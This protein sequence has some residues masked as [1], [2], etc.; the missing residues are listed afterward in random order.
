MKSRRP[1][2]WFARFGA[3]LDP[4]ADHGEVARLRGAVDVAHRGAALG[5]REGRYAG[6]IAL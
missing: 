3:F 2:A 1:H 5:R 6:A 4:D